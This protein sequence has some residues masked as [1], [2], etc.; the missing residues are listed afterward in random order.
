[1]HIYIF[2]SICRGEYLQD[3]DIDLLVC[4]QENDTHEFDTTKFSIYHYTR[5]KELWS[6]GNPFAWHLYLES[7]LVY[8]S[9]D[10]DYIKNLGKPSFY[11]NFNSD[12]NKFYMLYNQSM[13]ELLENKNIIF[14]LSCIFLALRNIA[15]CYSLSKMEK[16]IFSRKSPYLIDIPI[17]LN[18]KIFTILE[19]ARIL[20][21]R[22]I[23]RSIIDSEIEQIKTERE[24][25][26]SWLKKLE[27]YCL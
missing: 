1:M 9:D 2:G 16:P 8:A 25:I 6:E 10:L 13:T 11:C 27:R 22:G 15:T 23:G 21:T 20:S 26:E 17:N 3:S 5:L 14:N 18:M 19:K 7:K 4:I 24:V 12:F